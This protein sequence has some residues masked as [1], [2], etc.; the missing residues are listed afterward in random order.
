MGPSTHPQVPDL[1]AI[2]VPVS[3]GG[4]ISGIALAAKALKPSVLV[5]AAEPGGSNAAADAAASKARG[6]LVG[7]CRGCGAG[8]GRV[9]A[10]PGL[11]YIPRLGH[12][13]ALPPTSRPTANRPLPP[14]PPPPPP[15]PTPHPALSRHAQARDHRRRPAGTAGGA[16][17]AGCAGQGGRGEGPCLVGHRPRR[18]RGFRAG[19]LTMR[20]RPNGAED[21]LSNPGHLHPRPCDC[22][23]HPHPTHPPTPGGGRER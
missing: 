14:D 22:P 15:T 3:G 2:V 13:I 8:R 20:Q 4:M 18:H 21:P 19:Q 7:G 23:P 12:P 5:V 10:M 6:A 1:D 11:T 16:D 9:A 17:V